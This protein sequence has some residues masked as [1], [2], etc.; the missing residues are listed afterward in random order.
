M[1]AAGFRHRGRR[2]AL[3]QAGQGMLQ[4]YAV[5]ITEWGGLWLPR[6][7]LCRTERGGHGV[8]VWPRRAQWWMKVYLEGVTNTNLSNGVRSVQSGGLKIAVCW[9]LL[10]VPLC[11]RR[12]KG[13]LCR[14][15][16]FLG[17]MKI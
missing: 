7:P 11:R 1:I 8:V 16:F 9:C 13:T 10:L 4:L 14:K 6:L 12:V 3:H 15:Y 17:Y 2:L 5:P